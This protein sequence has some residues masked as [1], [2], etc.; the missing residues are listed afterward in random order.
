MN[1][2]RLLPPPSGP[3]IFSV[4]RASPERSPFLGRTREGGGLNVASGLSGL[5]LGFFGFDM[6]EFLKT[7]GTGASVMNA[8][9]RASIRGF[10]SSCAQEAAHERTA[11]GIPSLLS[12]WD[13][14]AG[15]SSI[16]ESPS[17]IKTP[18]SGTR[19]RVE[20]AAI[21]LW[22]IWGAHR[23]TVKVRES[24]RRLKRSQNKGLK[25]SEE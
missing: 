21:L 4:P 22:I 25:F 14:K 8:R 2:L 9:Q 19:K 7:E 16:S 10:C 5:V 17:R 23:K 18:S 13:V 15:Q 12:T 20:I 6:I 11:P 24:K 3:E 1:G